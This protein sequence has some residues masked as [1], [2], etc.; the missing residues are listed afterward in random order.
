MERSAKKKKKHWV[1]RILVFLLLL[2]LAAVILLGIRLVPTASRLQ[3]ALTARNCAVTLDVALDIQ[4]LTA[5][6]Q[7]FLSILSRLTGLE[8]TEW[9]EL[10]LRGGYDGEAIRMDVYGRQGTLLTQLYL[11][12]DC[13]AM[14]L[15]MVYD[16]AHSYLTEKA[17]LLAR[18]LPDW[19]MGD[20][21]S[22]QQ[23]EAAFG[24]E[25]GE[26]PDMQEGMER[27]QSG[28]SLPAMCGIILAADQWDREEQKLV[29]HITDTD[30]RLAY[31]RQ[32]A[33]KKG[34]SRWL[35][36][37]RGTEL[38]VT[39]D[40]VGSRVQMEITGQ[41]PEAEQLTD[42]SA[43]LLW[44]GYTPAEGEISLMDQQVLNELSALLELL[45]TVLGQ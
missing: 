18:V 1:L 31:I 24:L 25:L 19:N 36:L 41:L 26:L 39:I 23:L 10:T 32:L 30:S 3:R 16:R 44:E 33:E 29:Y 11:T 2:I 45:E 12:S 35:Q 38:E 8:E 5:D 4:E 6:Q 9:Q 43:E 42:W 28:L 21:I 37:P 13:Q 20:Y 17:G 27:I 15:H 14:N 22:L 7:K 40:L 34:D